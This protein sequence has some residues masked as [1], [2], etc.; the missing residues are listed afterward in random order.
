LPVCELFV[1]SGLL[2]LGANIASDATSRFNRARPV[3]AADP[4]RLHFGTGM[5]CIGI[6]GLNGG[7]QV[8]S[9][10]AAFG[11]RSSCLGKA[12]S[13]PVGSRLHDPV[14]KQAQAV[15]PASCWTG[16]MHRYIAALYGGQSQHYR[17]GSGNVLELIAGSPSPTVVATLS[18]W[19][20]KS[21][22]L[23]QLAP[24]QLYFVSITDSHVASFHSLLFTSCG[25]AVF[26]FWR[27]MKKITD[28]QKAAAMKVLTIALAEARPAPASVAD[29]TMTVSGDHI[30]TY[31]WAFSPTNLKATTV[32]RSSTQSRVY[33]ITFALDT[34]TLLPTATAALILAETLMPAGSGLDPRMQSPSPTDQTM[35]LRTMTSGT[36]KLLPGDSF[37]HAVA[38]SYDVNGALVLD[39][40]SVSVGT[41]RS[42]LETKQPCTHGVGASFGDATTRCHGNLPPAQSV[43]VGSGFYRTTS[44]AVT[45]SQVNMAATL[46]EHDDVGGNDFIDD[47]IHQIAS[48]SFP[49]RDT[50]EY[51]VTKSL[52]TP[53]TVSSTVSDPPVYSAGTVPSCTNANDGTPCLTEGRRGG[54]ATTEGPGRP[55]APTGCHLS[56][57]T[58]V[59]STVTTKTRDA[60]VEAYS[61]AGTKH[62]IYT[63]TGNWAVAPLG[64]RCAMLLG[65]YVPS[66]GFGCYYSTT[67]GD[68]FT[69][70]IS[71]HWAQ[72]YVNNTTSLS[73]GVD[74]F[75]TNRQFGGLCGLLPLQA[76]LP[77]VADYNGVVSTH[78]MRATTASD[79][80]GVSVEGDIQARFHE[81][82][83]LD[84]GGGAYDS[85]SLMSI[86]NPTSIGGFGGTYVWD[87]F[88]GTECDSATAML[89]GT[90]TDAG[91]KQQTS[92]GQKHASDRFI[93]GRDTFLS[94][95]FQYAARRSL[96]GALTLPDPTKDFGSSIAMDRETITG[97]YPT[98]SWPSFVGWA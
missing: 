30:G 87:D 40:Y 47:Y 58:Y 67:I 62:G 7:V 14:R 53:S 10:G 88:S 3:F 44:G 31:G 42:D 26:K 16:L 97:G 69:S 61:A 80:T 1:E 74:S 41:T 70:S 13:L 6:G 68:T 8:G 57:S 4:A 39:R 35:L 29:I 63:T 94:E 33:E 98:V 23:L 84:F 56:S 59:N 2:D 60:S 90:G 75:S 55:T 85:G 93:H 20:D 43:Q 86:Y 27:S 34:Y 71:D 21:W 24:G 12:G 52:G 48:S 83:R 51:I 38:S 77:S 15:L 49:Y 66:G 91:I 36:A 28:A 9:R 54:S 92:A 95:D 72:S 25:S 11:L 17:A 79:P 32:L 65:Q 46:L 50:L 5:D 22:G 82:L 96:L 64:D 81:Q 89:F 19:S 37:D 45:R 18:P 76:L 73:C 78:L